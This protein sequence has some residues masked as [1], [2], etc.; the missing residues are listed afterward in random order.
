MTTTH[1]NTTGFA[2]VDIADG[3]FRLLDLHSEPFA[4][5]RETLFRIADYIFPFPPREM[6]V[7]TR[8]QVAAALSR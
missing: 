5:P 3:E 7:W 4:L 1:F 8:E 6:C 2:N